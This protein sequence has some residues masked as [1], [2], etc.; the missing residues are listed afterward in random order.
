MYG[1]LDQL[2]KEKFP[3]GERIL[4]LHTGGGFGLFPVKERFFD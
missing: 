1:L 2:R 3:K 4:F